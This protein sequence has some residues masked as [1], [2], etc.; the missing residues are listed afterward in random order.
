MLSLKLFNFNSVNIFFHICNFQTWEVV[1]S[2]HRLA[3]KILK[4]MGT[5][6]CNCKLGYLCNDPN[7][8][9]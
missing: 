3:T 2:A 8:E 1:G 5:F 4:L 6:Q 9:I 7:S